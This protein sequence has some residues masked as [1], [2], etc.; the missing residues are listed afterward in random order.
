MNYT[1]G[2]WVVTPCEKQFVISNKDGWYDLAVVRNIS[3]AFDNAANARLISAAP[4]LYE[5]LKLFVN[6]SSCQTEFP[7]ACEQAE[8]AL[9]KAEGE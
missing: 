5:A 6:N 3:D 9:S 8:K 4:E 1:K 7:Y 2:P